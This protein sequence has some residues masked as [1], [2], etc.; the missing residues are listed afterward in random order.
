MIFTLVNPEAD[1]KSDPQIYMSI[2]YLATVLD[3]NGYKVNVID[4]QVENAKKSLRR[5]LKKSDCVGFSVM[6]SQVKHALELS[7][8]IKEE[9]SDTSVIWG[10][11]H[12]TLFPAQTVSDKSVDFVMKDEAESGMVEFARYIEGKNNIKNVGGLVYP[13]SKDKEKFN[14][15]INPTKTCTDLND[16]SPPSW[17]LL[18]MKKYATEYIFG[19]ENFGKHLPIHSSR[20]C[21]YRCTFCINTILKWKNWR[22]LHAPNMINEIKILKDKYNLSFIKF[23]DENF[24]LDK[25]RVT[26]FC[27]SLIKEK[28]DL[29]WRA[30]SRT[31]YFNKHHINDDMLKLSK[32][33]GCK[34]M[35][36]GIESG[37]DRVL[38]DIIGKGVTVKDAI[39]SINACKK[40]EI[41]PVCSFMS[42]L[43][44]EAKKERLET[45]SL[46]RKIKKIYPRTV[47]IGPQVFRP[48]PGCELYDEIKNTIKEPK[49]LREWTTVNMFG[50]YVS[51]ASLPW[52]EDPKHLMNTFFYITLSES[53]SKGVAR[54]AKIPFKI[55]AK[56]RTE[57][58]MF[59]FP[60][61][62]E[63]YDIGK[64]GYYSLKNT[65]K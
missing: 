62:K 25:K 14:V 4:S 58:N 43:P 57:L 17:H 16:L 15:R 61:E 26:E 65:F 8:I 9:D 35:S 33:A 6:T 3:R 36:M 23:I 1:E 38:K 28:I 7:D 63:I 59:D 19:G 29:G 53:S 18:K 31:N 12:P 2:L 42:G 40:F 5:V 60:I 55:L 52:I 41:M 64:S 37:S 21:P 10:G 46:I 22:P 34:I 13:D 51:P 49:S 45:L 20:G 24:F 48:Y 50:G 39:N 11:I 54:I 44:G 27:N 32:K 56:L 30:S 47:I